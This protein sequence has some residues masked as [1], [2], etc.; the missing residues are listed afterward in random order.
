[1]NEPRTMNPDAIPLVDEHARAA[2]AYAGAIGTGRKHKGAGTRKP[3]K[4]IRRRRSQAKH[5]LRLARRR[6]N[7]PHKL[8]FADISTVNRGSF[9]RERILTRCQLPKPSFPRERWLIQTFQAAVVDRYGS[10]E[11]F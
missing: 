7:P 1:M 2:R 11:R 4:L 5:K 10:A 6:E 9:G 3:T 8:T